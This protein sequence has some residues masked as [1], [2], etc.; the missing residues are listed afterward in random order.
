M[1]PITITRNMMGPCHMQVCCIPEA[2]DEEILTLCNKQNIAG[3][4]NGWTQVCHEST[5]SWPNVAPVPCE[6]Y[7]G[8]THYMVSC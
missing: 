8:R 7:P 2:T 4:V 3:T 1:N 5:D 6:M